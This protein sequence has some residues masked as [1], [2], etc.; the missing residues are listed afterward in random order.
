MRA[1]MKATWLFFEKRKF[2]S[3]T[4]HF[5]HFVWAKN[6]LWK[7]EERNLSEDLSRLWNGARG[8]AHE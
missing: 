5:I 1:E 4:V 8:P 6:E 7:R 3:I 2:S